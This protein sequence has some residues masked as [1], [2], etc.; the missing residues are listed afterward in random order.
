VARWP[1]AVEASAALRAAPLSNRGLQGIAAMRDKERCRPREPSTMR[2]CFPAATDRRT[3]LAVDQILLTDFGDELELR[4]RRCPMPMNEWQAALAASLPMRRLTPDEVRELVDRCLALPELCCLAAERGFDQAYLYASYDRLAE[5][6][7]ATPGSAPRIPGL[8]LL[9][10]HVLDSLIQCDFEA[11]AVAD[12]LAHFDERS[13]HCEVR[14]EWVIA[15]Q[16][17]G[18]GSA[19]DDALYRHPD[20]NEALVRLEAAVRD[21]RHDEALALGAAIVD[22]TGKHD[23]CPHPV[24]LELLGRMRQLQG[25]FR[26]SELLLRLAVRRLEATL[27]GGFRRPDLYIALLRAQLGLV[28]VSFEFGDLGGSLGRLQSALARHLDITAGLGAQFAPAIVQPATHELAHARLDALDGAAWLYQQLGQP[29]VAWLLAR[30]ALGLAGVLGIEGGQP[31]RLRLLLWRA[32]RDLGYTE[33]ADE[34]YRMAEAAG[35]VTPTDRLL[36]VTSWLQQG[37]LDEAAAALDALKGQATA[38]DDH[39]PDLALAS[40]LLA[41]ARGDTA[42]ATEWYAH[43]VE[44]SDRLLERES[45]RCGGEE[46]PLRV[47]WHRQYEHQLLDHLLAMTPPQGRA[48]ALAFGAVVRRRHLA[49]DMLRRVAAAREVEPGLRAEIAELSGRIG[50]THLIDRAA[51]SIDATYR[52]LRDERNRREAQ[53]AAAVGPFRIEPVDLQALAQALPAGTALIEYIDLPPLPAWVGRPEALPSRRVAFWMVAD[54]LGMVELPDLPAQDRAVEAWLAAVLA[55]TV[56]PCRLGEALRE[57]VLDPILAG[58]PLDGLTAL[59][60]VPAG[61]LIKVPFGALPVDDVPLLEM[62]GV[63][64]L[65]SSR[66]LLRAPPAETP[67]SAPA[68]FA[69]P[70]FDH[71]LAPGEDRVFEPLPGARAEG[72]EVAA[73]FGVT[74]TCGDAASEP[75]FRRLRSPLLLHVATHGYFRERPADAPPAAGTSAALRRADAL[76]AGGLAFAGANARMH[77]RPGDTDIGNGIVGNDDI[78][79]MDLAGTRL[80]VLSACEAAGGSVDITEGTT[81]LRRAFLLA[82]ARTLVMSLWPVPDHECRLLM[83]QFYALLAAGMTCADALN[84]AQ[85]GTRAKHPDLFAWGGWV[86]VG[87]GGALDSAAVQMLREGIAAAAA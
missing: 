51:L 36:Q 31:A 76:R 30:G 13:A 39:L 77:G 48:I 61:R 83:R 4:V 19:P 53:L 68:V 37:R 84:A 59:V 71:G 16:A 2:S 81:G 20:V 43:A 34:S 72:L 57:R 79:G 9:H 23:S 70:D 87:D 40:G 67:T 86:C 33:L 63:R 10:W 15:S 62:L 22:A 38:T 5:A 1:V 21:G 7:A 14:T 66:D 50:A 52:H 49:L 24:A 41:A 44:L 42:A 47:A 32:G 6:Q 29:H 75:A 35:V 11:S 73:W 3:A 65:T 26:G 54:R 18:P 74:A 85:R 64:Y 69:D 12:L 82:G 25:D 56:D 27:A 60:I 45:A 46:L 58:L 8:C 55:E 17:G 28:R 78:V 80:V